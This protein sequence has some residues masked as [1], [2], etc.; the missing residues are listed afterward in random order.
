MAAVGKPGFRGGTGRAFL[1]ADWRSGLV[2]IGLTI[3]LAISPVSAGATLPGAG[4]A[5]R[6]IV[7]ARATWDTGWLQ[8]EIFVGL[9]ERS[10]S[11]LREVVAKIHS[12]LFSPAE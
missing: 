11:V 5:A 8:T 6:T 1:R 3:L 9:L 10:G 12:V 4:L 7:M 2:G